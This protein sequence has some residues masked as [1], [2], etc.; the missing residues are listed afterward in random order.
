ML[1]AL[2]GGADSTALLQ[3]ALHEVAGRRVGAIRVGAIVVDHGLQPG[4]GD[5]ARDVAEWARVAGADPVNVVHVRVGEGPGPEAAARSARRDALAAA[6]RRLGA[7]AVLLG[8]TADDQAETVLLGLARGSGARSLAGMAE[9]TEGYRRPFLGLT[10]SLV[11]AAVTEEVRTPWEDPHN[12]DQAFARA[13]VRHRVLPTLEAELG[14]GVSAALARTAALLRADADALDGLAEQALTRA[15][16][17]GR[18]AAAAELRLDVAVLQT[19]PA[20][21]R[22]RVLRRAAL[23]A[24]SPPSDLSATHVLEVDALVTGW[25][26]QRRVD[27]PGEVRAARAGGALTFVRA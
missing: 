14:P 6:A 8:H 25:R 10:R 26:G 21:V 17:S 3:A 23:L 18:V 1:V 12:A 9:V 13:R 7:E 2:S 4:S 24:G 15:I 5:L 11:R 22:T 27:L 19:L 16:G 20:A